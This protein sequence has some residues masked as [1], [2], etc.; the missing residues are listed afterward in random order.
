MEGVTSRWGGAL[1]W[2]SGGEPHRA[3]TMHVATYVGAPFLGGHGGRLAAWLCRR[4]SVGGSGEQEV[5]S[6]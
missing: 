6:V 1:S 5:V 3:G 4:A 2:A